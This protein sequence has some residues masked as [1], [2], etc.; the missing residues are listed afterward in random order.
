MA[1]ACGVI[2]SKETGLAELSG[3]GNGARLINPLDVDEIANAILEFLRSPE[4]R[5]ALATQARA[6]VI[7]FLSPQKIAKQREESIAQLINQRKI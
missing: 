1:A 5:I 2:V 7:D 4:K 6:R 3:Q